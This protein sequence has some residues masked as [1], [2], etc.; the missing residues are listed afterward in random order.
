MNVMAEQTKRSDVIVI[1]GGPSG[2][3]VAAGLA[4]R[5]LDVRVLERKP[6]IGQNVVCTGI[7]G[8]DAFDEFSLDRGAVIREVQS[9]RLVSPFETTVSYEHARPFAA[10]VDRGTFDNSLAEAARSEGAKIE[11]GTR[12]EDIHVERNGVVLTTSESGRAASRFSAKMAVIATGVD[13]AL[14]RKCGLGAPKDFLKGAQSEVASP[15]GDVTTIFV[16]KSVAPG[17]FAWMVPA[18]PGKARVGLLT[19]TDA[20][21]CLKNFIRKYPD[22]LQAEPETTAIQTKV[23]AQGLVSRTTGDRILSVGEAAG[24]IK[25]TTGGGISYGLLC[26]EL[27]SKVVAECFER[28]SFGAGAL[29]S[30]E[31]LWRKAIQKEIV[32]GYYT[33]KMCSRLSDARVESLFRLAQTDG[34]IPIIRET[35]DFDWH[36][37]LI[38]ALLQR[39][40]FMK[41]FKI[42]KDHLGPGSLS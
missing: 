30:Y 16:G 26:A 33:R 42:M 3:R 22:Y 34:I 20:R 7:I 28:R 18:S 8:L 25:T 35:A 17:A 12:V 1:G 14:Q 15:E 36:S 5:G 10:I 32:V 2:L 29:A 6:R 40:S 13:Y 9:V 24:Q 37:G 38:L 27:A 41:F 31:I 4:A 39:L 19:G 21:A 23:I 11:L